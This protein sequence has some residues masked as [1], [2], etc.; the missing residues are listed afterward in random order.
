MSIDEGLDNV[1]ERYEKLLHWELSESALKY[2][3]N[4]YNNR[5]E[6]LFNESTLT[7]YDLIKI[8]EYMLSKRAVELRLKDFEGELE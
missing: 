2:A 4:E 7:D 8:A 5:L 1:K 3:Y 6:L